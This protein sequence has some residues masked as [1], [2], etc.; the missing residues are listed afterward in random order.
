MKDPKLRHPLLTARHL[1]LAALI[2]MR[3]STMGQ[4]KTNTGSTDVQRELVDLAVDYGYPEHAIRVIDEDL[5][6]SGS[7]TRNRTGWDE[8]LRLIAAGVV[9][10]VFFFDVK[11]LAREVGD[12]NELL[13]L[14]RYHNVVM[15]LDRRPTDPNNHNDA[16][17]L[18]VQAAFAEL[19]NRSRADLM[20]RCRF[21][22]AAKGE[23]VSSLPVG[24]LEEKDGTFQFDPEVRPAIEDVI[25]TFF[26]V[27]TLR[28][29]V[30]RL[31]A[32]GKRMPTRYRKLGKKG[33]SGRRL[34]WKR[35][36]IDMVRR[37]LLLPAYAGFYA[38]GL[39]E[40]RPEFG[41][42]PSGS[43]RRKRVPK[44]KWILIPN[45][46]PAYLTVEQQDEIR[47]IL[48][49]N[50]FAE[51]SRPRNGDA[52]CQGHVRCAR[53]GGMLT[54][55]Y[56]RPNHGPHRYQCNVQST[57]FGDAPCCSIQGAELDAAVERAVLAALRT[58][59]LEVLRVALAATR[60]A[61]RTHTA[62]IETDRKRLAYQ[63]EIA[64]QR[65]EETDPRNAHVFTFASEQLEQRMQEQAQFEQQL[66]L[67]P[68]RPSADTNEEELRELCEIAADVPRLW[69]HP[70]V[71]NRERKE[72]LRC[73]IRSVIVTTTRQSIEVT[74]SWA[75]GGQTPLRLWRRDGVDELIRQR[76]AEGMTAR[77]I[78]DWLAAGDPTTGQRW[79]RTTA[80]VYQALGRIGVRPHPARQTMDPHRARAREL[81]ESGKSLREIAAL[82][83]REELRTPNGHVWDPQAAHRALGLTIGRDRLAQV[84]RELLDDARRRGLTH[85]ETADEFN[86]RRVPRGSSRPWTADAVR[87]RSVVLN[88]AARRADWATNGEAS[89][90]DHP[91]EK[92]R[93]GVMHQRPRR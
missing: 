33:V 64:R 49:E 40:H 76:H 14:C 71:S 21:A 5:G 17:L 70:T 4:V 1:A 2:Y 84:H 48:Q 6:K 65:F 36:T 22:K 37:M 43:P 7:T 87:Q 26:E 50:G 55:A 80:A 25:R 86:A 72:I 19:D 27:R 42:C 56:P 75:S 69:S 41:L 82:F 31:N 15:V 61:E 60:E 57:K 89:A 79:E 58:P 47:R 52:L 23:T 24:W 28:G 11:R 12:F 85:L 62:R 20:R 68:E 16:A 8:M 63:V 38:Y 88:R 35:P 30:A 13:V 54:V 67:M 66:A 44:E 81:F 78:R 92:S 46:H 18:H 90:P 83:N 59:P 3:Q 34:E 29:T 32:E 74:V 53:C 10:A 39:T 51:R 73:L 77:Q 91:D 93:T 9:G 45:H